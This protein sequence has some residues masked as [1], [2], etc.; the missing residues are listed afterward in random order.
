MCWAPGSGVTGSPELP[1][2]RIGGLPWASR[3]GS[4]VRVAFHSEQVYR[5]AAAPAPNIGYLAFHCAASARTWAWVTESLVSAQV[6][7]SWASRWL[8]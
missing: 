7:A 8:E 4:G 6:T 2:T 5:L 1:T 3:F